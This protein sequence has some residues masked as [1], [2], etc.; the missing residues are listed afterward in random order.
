MAVERDARRGVR[1][2]KLGQNFLV[3]RNILDVIERLAEL[4]ADDVVLEIGGGPGV[5]S[6]R[7]AARSPIVHVVELDRGSSPSLRELLEPLPN[8]TL[9]IADALELD[10]ATLDPPPTRWSPTCRTGSPRP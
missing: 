6:Q 2:V 1:M 4:S 10:L 8:V 9:H 7:L 5:L 3:D